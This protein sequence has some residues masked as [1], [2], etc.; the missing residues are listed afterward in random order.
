MSFKLFFRSNIEL[1][2]LSIQYANHQPNANAE[3]WAG[4]IGG[5]TIY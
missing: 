4:D 1:K 2:E 3:T 5:S